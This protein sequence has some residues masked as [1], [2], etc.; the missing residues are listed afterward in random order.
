VARFDRNHWHHHS[1]IPSFGD[2][3]DDYYNKLEL[4]QAKGIFMFI[5]SFWY[6]RT[7]NYQDLLR[8]IQGDQYQVII[9]GHSCGVS[10]RTM[11]NMIFED[12][13]CKSI[14]IYHHVS[15]GKDNY[16]E[17]THEIARHFKNKQE[18]R[19]KIVPFDKESYMPQIH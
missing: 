2:E 7:K 19:R 17:I 12:K 3:L 1:E 14:K 4:H 18:M 13:N 8:F 16:T 11:L 15:K 10:D 6:F 5:K 9:L